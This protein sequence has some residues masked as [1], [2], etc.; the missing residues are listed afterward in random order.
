[1]ENA[2]KNS[3]KLNFCETAAEPPL[4]RRM[5]CLPAAESCLS[6]AESCLPAAESCLSAD[7]WFASRQLNHASR[8]LNHVSRSLNHASRPLNGLSPGAALS[9]CAACGIGF[10]FRRLSV[11]PGSSYD[12]I[13]SIGGHAVNNGVENR[14]RRKA[15]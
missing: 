2:I 4:S 7:E 10:P 5:V 15:Y 8:Q 9:V 11:F 1:M 12:V 6:A 14:K 3:S 13:I